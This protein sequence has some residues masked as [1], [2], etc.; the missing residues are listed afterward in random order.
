MDKECY[1]MIQKW[2]YHRNLSDEDI[3][4]IK[5]QKERKEPTQL[6]FRIANVIMGMEDE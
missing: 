2:E 4:K 1:R 5:L 6:D 3:R